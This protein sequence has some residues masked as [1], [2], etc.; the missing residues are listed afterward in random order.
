MNIIN[1]KSDGELMPDLA[2]LRE[3]IAAVKRDLAV[4]LEHLKT[5]AAERADTAG[6]QMARQ[7]TDMYDELA[8]RGGRAVK[9]LAGHIEQQPFASALVAFSIGFLLSRLARR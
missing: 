8:S 3:D 5:G 7:V 1:T 2:A 6:E 9:S 4:A